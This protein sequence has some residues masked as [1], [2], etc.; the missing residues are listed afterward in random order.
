MNNAGYKRTFFVV[1]RSYVGP[2]V[3]P[4]ECAGCGRRFQPSSR[5]LRCPACRSRTICVCGRPK[6][7]KSATCG[8]C[9]T[10]L[11]SANGNWRGGRTRHKRGYVMVH[12]PNHPRALSGPYVFEHILVVEEMLGRFLEPFESVHHRNGVKDDN[13]PENLELWTRPHPTG[14]RVSDAVAWA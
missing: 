6:Q 3:E 9:R 13:R 10:E 11:G 14:I 7:A 8:S 12:V 1:H 5:H 2:M 4:K